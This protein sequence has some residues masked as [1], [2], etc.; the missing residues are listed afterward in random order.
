MAWLVGVDEAGYGPNLGPLVIAVTAWRFDAAGE[1][2]DLYA[3]LAGAVAREPDGARLAIADSKRLYKP[4]GGLGLL[5][6]GVGAALAAGEIPAPT[7]W[8]ELV[9]TLAADPAGRRAELPW[10]AG[11]DPALADFAPAGEMLGAACRAAAVSPPV[12]RAR[13]VFPAEFNH[14]V[15]RYETKGAALSHVTIDLL[16]EVLQQTSGPVRCVLDKHGGRNRYGPLLQHQFPEAWIETLAESRPVSRYAW[17]DREARIEAAFQTKG[18]SWLPAALASMAAKYLRELA[19]QAFNAFWSSHVPGL[20]PTAGYPVDAKRF[21][22]EIA[23]KQRELG[24][25]DR[26][27]WRKR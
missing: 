14:L 10:H 11:F 23:D 26:L 16:A 6:R 12:V 13:L 9:E 22:A 1:P 17:G 8:T 27:L 18:E 3:L 19:M 2:P 25:E 4:G 24:I 7:T 15:D 20:K 21:K 5:E